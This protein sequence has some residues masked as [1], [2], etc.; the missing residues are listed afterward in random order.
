MHARIIA[1][2]YLQTNGG[3]LLLGHG[4]VINDVGESTSF[5]VLHYYPEFRVLYQERVQK[6]DNVAVLRLFHN[7]DFVHNQLLARLVG[8]IHLLNSDLGVGSK[9]GCHVHRA[10]RTVYITSVLSIY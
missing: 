5:H 8:Q 9:R 2:N 1:L 10:R 3:D 4:I 6:V 7:K